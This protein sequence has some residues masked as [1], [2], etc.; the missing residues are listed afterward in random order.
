MTN[1]FQ[2][3]QFHLPIEI[4][5]HIMKYLPLADRICA[6][7]VCR[8]WYEAA[9]E[10]GLHKNEVVV[11]HGDLTRPLEVLESSSGSFMHFVFKEVELGNKLKGFWD[12][13]CPQMRSLALHNCD[14]SE[15][16]FV[17]ILLKCVKLESLSINGCRELL[18]SG[19]V[20][21]VD[22]DISRL[23]KT[24][25]KL[26]RLCLAFNRYLSDALF[27]RFVA[28]ASNLEDL[29]LKGC[30][31]SFNR[32]LY[33]KFYPDF[34]MKSGNCVASESVLTFH[35]ILTYVTKQA[36]MLQKLRF[37]CTLIDNAA[38][39]QLATVPLLSL[40]TLHLQSCDQ[41]TDA[42]I[43]SLAEHQNHLLE[44]DLSACSRVG[45]VAVNSI[46][47]KLVHLESLNLRNCRSLTDSGVSTLNKLK[48]LRNLNLS[49]CE[50]VTGKGIETALCCSINPRF[51]RLY[52]TAL[53]VDERTVCKLAEHLPGL[54]HLDLGWCFNGVTDKSLQMICKYQVRLQ[55]LKLAACNKITDAGLTG[56]GL[57]AE[58]DGTTVTSDDN[59]EA[60][61]YQDIIGSEQV[62][63]GENGHYGEN[64]DPGFNISLRTKAEQEII[65][66]AKRKKIVSQLCEENL[67][68]T[69]S[70]GHSLI[71]LKGLQRLDLSGCNRITD[72]SL[73]YA[74][75]F[76]EL[77]Y[78]DLSQCQQITHVGLSYLAVHNPSIETLILS[79]CYN[80]ADSGVLSFIKCLCRLKH[81][82]LKGC[83]QLTDITLEGIG[84]H[85][86]IL[87]YLDVSLCSTMTT[88]A[89]E[90]TEL[91][92]PSLY[93]V[94]K[95]GL[96]SK[97][98]SQPNTEKFSCPSPPPPPRRF[99]CS[100]MC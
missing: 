45:D 49:H 62:I 39:M 9:Q 70:S 4:V 59:S 24:L 20:L 64:V 26:R 99:K 100:L 31:I 1:G 42:G 46:S 55:F 86:D 19:R 73:K 97:N 84:K 56:M 12:K 6:S 11:L 74:F 14:V 7:Q 79:H 95:L 80:I 87:K 61:Q 34:M 38:L 96:I 15:K 78:L 68:S 50:Q 51:R 13:F 22:T 5:I 30:Y 2:S 35:N 67:T 36:K 43:V 82:E 77:R 16:M 23:I 81:L 28:V 3:V 91:A 75:R 89:A 69:D 10:F 21:E 40:T 90:A 57:T 47:D 98:N 65:N 83:T 37:G 25:K 53:A 58:Q 8:L 94:H 85:C 44:L 71:H 92:L 72:V 66:D 27:N 76:K 93:T 33:K 54:T 52:L 29:S 18:M 32:G 48:K 60:M 88:E 17:D 63:N 41:L